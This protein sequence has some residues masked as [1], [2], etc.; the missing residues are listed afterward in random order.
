MSE[1]YPNES[2]ST[3]YDTTRTLMSIFASIV[4]CPI[5]Q[6]CHRRRVHILSNIN[7]NLLLEILTTRVCQP[8]PGNTNLPQIL[9][10]TSCILCPC[11]GQLVPSLIG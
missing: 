2:F 11:H 4:C 6:P 1:L 9:P 3:I 7:C 5:P 8:T 10:F